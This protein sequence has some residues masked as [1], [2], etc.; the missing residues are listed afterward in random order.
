MIPG[1]KN[2]GI[3]N[4]LSPLKGELRTEEILFFY[5][6]KEMNFSKDIVRKYY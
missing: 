5:E 4:P 2:M 1:S 3:I 6:F